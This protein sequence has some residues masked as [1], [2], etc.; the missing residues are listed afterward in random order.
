MHEHDSDLKHLLAEWGRACGGEQCQRLGFASLERI[1]EPA[2]NDDAAPNVHRVQ[3]AVQ[4]LQAIGRWKEAR[5]L[6]VEYLQPATDEARKL[7][8][9]E[10]LGVSMSR[11]SYYAYLNAAQ[12]FVAGALW[13]DSADTQAGA[14]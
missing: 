13:G 1:R 5:V 8:V 11:A 12:L 14:A 10:S 3:R 2:A 7:A 6:T 9:L 4:G